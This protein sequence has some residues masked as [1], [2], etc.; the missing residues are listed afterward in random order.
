MRRVRH[1]RDALRLR[2]Q[3]CLS[4]RRTQRYDMRRTGMQSRAMCRDRRRRRMTHP[5]ATDT[6]HSITASVAAKSMSAH[7]SARKPLPAKTAAAVTTATVTT[8]TVTAAAV[9]A[10]TCVTAA[11]AGM[12]ATATP[13]AAST[14][15]GGGIRQCRR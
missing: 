13:S 5:V 8:A 11:S 6:G 14:A 10:A 7:A 2:A 1:R 15:G 12:D 9:T 4:R 3:G